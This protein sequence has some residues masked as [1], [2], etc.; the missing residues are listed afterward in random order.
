MCARPCN[1]LGHDLILVLASSV[2][3]Y[4]KLLYYL[5]YVQLYTMFDVA[6]R[7]CDMIISLEEGTDVQV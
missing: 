4:P 3:T 6:G 5:F 1:V 2:K 7:L